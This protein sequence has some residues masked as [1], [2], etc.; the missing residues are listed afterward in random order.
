[1]PEMPSS[2]D[3]HQ[4][5]QEAGIDTTQS[6]ALWEL[7]CQRETI[8]SDERVQ[9]AESESK[10]FDI[11][12]LMLYLG[13]VLVCSALAWIL[14]LVG[15]DTGGVA[16]GS[17]CLLAA[18]YLLGFCAAGVML[19]RAGWKT[20]GH[21]M[22][23]IAVCLLPLLVAS[24]LRAL[25]IWPVDEFDS[26]HTA[27]ERVFF[28]EWLLVGI[29]TM[30]AAII[31][32]ARSHFHLL[33][34][35]ALGGLYLV[36]GVLWV[37]ATGGGAE[38][39]GGV[40]AAFHFLTALM[41][42]AVGYWLDRRRLRASGFWA[43]LATCTS[44]AIMFGGLFEL[45]YSVDSGFDGV[46]WILLILVSLLGLLVGVLFQR[47]TYLVWGSIGIFCF[48]CWLSGKVADGVLL[49]L[50]IGAAGL[51][52]IW[53]G[54]TYQRQAASVRQKLLGSLPDKLGRNV[55]NKDSE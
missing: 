3:F 44:V 38:F 20:P 1:M 36:T 33:M 16:W 53:A 34:I 2:D 31:V 13:T 27:V 7:L 12:H 24:G 45:G 55:P 15:D 39:E 25:G 50:I 17:I 40:V 26:T 28:W 23:T 47:V 9:P 30:I 11:A 41:A 5:A 51:L 8:A 4:A 49:P 32:F 43:H 6:K 46:I 29:A 52:M 21:L 35:P 42:F 54:I 10:H 19:E 14:F 22:F 37:A 18:L 48:V